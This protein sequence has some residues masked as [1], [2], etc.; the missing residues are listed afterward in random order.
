MRL[1]TVTGLDVPGPGSR[2]RQTTFSFED[3]WT[4]RSLSVLVPRP[5]GPRNCFQSAA[6]AK[7]T[8]KTTSNTYAGR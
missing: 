7:A 2:V 1:P 8:P 4:G 5:P 3:H 6:A